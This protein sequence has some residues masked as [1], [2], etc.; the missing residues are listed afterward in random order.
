MTDDRIPEDEPRLRDAIARLPAEVAPG[1][2]LWP[3]IRAAVDAGRVVALPT[4]QPPPARSP[5][6]WMRLAAAAAVLVI[7]SAAITWRVMRTRVPEAPV[8]AAPEPANPALARFAS[9]ERLAGELAATLEEKRATLD[10]ATHAVLERSLRTI[11]EALLEAR[12]ALESDP[13]SAAIRT[14]V[15]AA[16]RHKL[17]FLRRANDVADLRGI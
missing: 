10:P 16:Y 4:A 12:A 8:A 13:S 1:R 11:D 7:G 17:D 6:R 3:D 14:Y 9:Y 15:E 5:L 2:D